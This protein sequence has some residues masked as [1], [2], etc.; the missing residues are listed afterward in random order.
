MDLRVIPNAS[1]IQTFYVHGYS[2]MSDK[3]AL[4]SKDLK[5][6]PVP[7]AE[8]YIFATVERA[9]DFIKKNDLESKGFY[10]W[11]VFDC[12]GCRGY[13]HLSNE[14]EYLKDLMASEKDALL[15]GDFDED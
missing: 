11:K 4:C 15:S 10:V 12:Y 2:V 5:F 14:D 7:F 9:E 1:N 13:S 8:P 6:M 3:D